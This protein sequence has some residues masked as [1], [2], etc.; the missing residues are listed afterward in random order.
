M[1]IENIQALIAQG[2][3]VELS[4]ID[5]QKAYVTI[6]VFQTGNRQKGAAGNSYPSYAIS[7][8][9]L[10]PAPPPAVRIYT[11]NV[12]YVTTN[13]KDASG[14]IGYMDRPFG[15]IDAAAQYLPADGIVMVG[16]GQFNT[17]T[18]FKPGIIYELGDAYVDVYAP[19]GTG[20]TGDG[21]YKIYG[22]ATIDCY[23]NFFNSLNLS[24]VDIKCKRIRYYYQTCFTGHMFDSTILIEADEVISMYN[25]SFCLYLEGDSAKVNFNLH[26]NTVYVHRGFIGWFNAGVL[27]VNVYAKRLEH[28]GQDTFASLSWNLGAATTMNFRVDDIIINAVAANSFF[29]WYGV[30]NIYGDVTCNSDTS[31]IMADGGV[32]TFYGNINAT[33]GLL[34]IRGGGAKV[35]VKGNLISGRTGNAIY[36]NGA[37]TLNGVVKSTNVADTS[38]I[39]LLTAASPGPYVLNSAKIIG[40]V[41]KPAISN[42]KLMQRALDITG[43]L[44]T[45]PIGCTITIN[46]VPNVVSVPFNTDQATT[47]SDLNT[48][49]NALADISSTLTSA[50]KITITADV[51]TTQFS[52]SAIVDGT[53]ATIAQSLVTPVVKVFASSYYSSGASINTIQEPSSLTYYAGLE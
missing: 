38:P 13:G 35:E 50:T 27:N 23:S 19:S 30:L 36:C 45:G 46:G 43:A 41:T 25:G 6:G 40:D 15:S 1:E 16:P 5:T 26:A 51:Y 21:S 53:G 9:D 37:V 20:S 3:I 48:A 4:Q 17:F 33:L 14:Q 31:Y 11:P 28:V 49:I 32:S 34:N 12:A 52:I 39:V 24:T 22:N 18:G 7:L 47:Y 29:P 10:V 2:K 42:L 8:E 44:T